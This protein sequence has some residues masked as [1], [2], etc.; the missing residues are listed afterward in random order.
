MHV[1]Y[2]RVVTIGLFVA[3]GGG[4]DVIAARCIAQA[5]GY[6]RDRVLLATLAWDRLLIDP[7]PGPRS[8]AEFVGLRAVGE[9]N[10]QVLG[11][12]AAY[13]PSASTLPRLSRELGAQLML[14]DPLAGVRGIARQLTELAR[15]LGPGVQVHLV[16]VGG[17]VL[18][19]GH[20]PRLRSPTSDAMLLAACQ[21]LDTPVTVL[22]AGPGLDGELN[23]PEVVDYLRAAHGEVRTVLGESHTRAALEALEWHPS[24]ATALFVAASRGLRG[25]AEIRDAGL[26]VQVRAESATVWAV[27]AV[28]LRTLEL[29]L[30]IQESGTLEDVEAGLR[31]VLG[32]SELDRERS[33]AENLAKGNKATSVAAAHA[34]ALAYTRS[35][36]ERGVDYLT[37]RRLSEA[38]GAPGLHVELRRRL[39]ESDGRRY[40]APLWATR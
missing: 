7:V 14:L 32:W 17:D 20:E 2:A 23:G 18:A 29:P 39:I 8:H 21:H 11:S 37:F 4:G 5:L 16:D 35:A 15:L 28:E 22:V 9:S 26:Q 6:R 1:N 25:T 40:V 38:V 33:K 27:N 34:A 24:E 13:P 19:R 12:S 30:A 31:A 3:A 36:A 10:Y